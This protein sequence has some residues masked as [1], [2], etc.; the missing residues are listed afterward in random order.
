MANL[1]NFLVKRRNHIGGEMKIRLD[2]NNFINKKLTFKQH[3]IFET[4]MATPTK[5][6]RV[7][8][9]LIAFFTYVMTCYFPSFHR[10]LHEML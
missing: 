3:F 10:W 8:L 9:I 7:K 5:K 6:I 2:K 1:G 4:K